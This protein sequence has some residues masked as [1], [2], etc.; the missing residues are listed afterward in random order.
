MLAGA[1]I[2]TLD[3]GV[4]SAIKESKAILDSMASLRA[5]HAEHAFLREVFALQDMPEIGKQDDPR[6]FLLC[7]VREALTVMRAKAAP[8]ELDAYGRGI[9]QLAER[10]A[11]A[12]GSG[13]FGFGAKISDKERA[14]L[15]ELASLVS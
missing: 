8:D 7:R 5:T 3:F 2:P 10:V 12:S 13:W 1:V 14:Y 4:V 6:T 15:D 11:S 9:L